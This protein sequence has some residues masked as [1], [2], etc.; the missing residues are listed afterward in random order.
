MSKNKNFWTI[1]SFKNSSEWQ[2][3]RNLARDILSG[4][5][6]ELET[7]DLFWLKFVQK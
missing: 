7:P 3:S 5:G 2:E 1:E 6:F 4:L